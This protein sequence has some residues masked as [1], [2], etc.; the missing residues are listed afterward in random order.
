MRRSDATGV[1]ITLGCAAFYLLWEFEVIERFL[2]WLQGLPPIA[3]L[4]VFM[5]AF[6]LVSLPTGYVIRVLFA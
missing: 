3:G 6:F 5:P 2:V 1:I 4:A